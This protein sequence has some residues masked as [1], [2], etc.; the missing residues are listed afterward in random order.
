[1]TPLL[2]LLLLAQHFP[3]TDAHNCYPYE[4]QW[5]NRIDRRWVASFR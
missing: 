5:K 3:L 2:W 1:M 4:G